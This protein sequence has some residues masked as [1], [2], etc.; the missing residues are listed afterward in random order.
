MNRI[1]TANERDIEPRFCK[2]VQ[3]AVPQDATTMAVERVDLSPI[4]R[5]EG[6]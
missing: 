3:H 6:R 1:F 5:P 2:F 4:D